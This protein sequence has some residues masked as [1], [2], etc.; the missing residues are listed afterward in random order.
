[1]PP[2]PPHFNPVQITGAAP[3]NTTVQYSESSASRAWGV[4]CGRCAPFVRCPVSTINHFDTIFSAHVQKILL[5]LTPWGD[6][7]QRTFKQNKKKT[8]AKI[9]RLEK[10]KSAASPCGRPAASRGLCQAQTGPVLP[11]QPQLCVKHSNL[12]VCA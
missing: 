10:S 2:S 6:R 1:M 4:R 5:D 9:A 11:P 7:E 3:P 12:R 8:H